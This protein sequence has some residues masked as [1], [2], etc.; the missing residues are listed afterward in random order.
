MNVLYPTSHSAFRLFLGLFFLTLLFPIFG[1]TDSYASHG[2]AG[3]QK[4]RLLMPLMNAEDGKKVFVDKG[5]VSCHAING[6]GGHDAPSLD[7]HANLGMVNPF[8][9]AAKMWNHAS[10]MI[11]AQEEA[12]GE[13]V[14]F[15][16][17]ELAN[18][19]AFVHDDVA[20]HSFGEKNLT[21]AARKM[22]EHGHGG[23]PAVEVHAKEIGHAEEADHTEAPG[24]PAHK[25]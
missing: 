6:V 17:D 21:T 8:D 19:I 22:M 13:Q 5:C 10:G 24:A 2:D 15:S 11:A 9:F 23:G 16:G 18:I 1:A 4:T 3:G 25:D 12:F 7:D 20:Q 14:N